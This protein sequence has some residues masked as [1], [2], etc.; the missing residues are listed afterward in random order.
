MPESLRRGD[1]VRIRGEHW[2]VVACAGAVIRVRGCD[3]ANRLTEAAF[4]P[5]IEQT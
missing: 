5:S 2:K 4:L 1:R 3:A